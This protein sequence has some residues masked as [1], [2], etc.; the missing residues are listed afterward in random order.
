MTHSHIGCCFHCFNFAISQSIC[1]RGNHELFQMGRKLDQHQ[2][3]TVHPFSFS[4]N[5][6]ELAIA[7]RTT[8]VGKNKPKN[9]VTPHFILS[10]M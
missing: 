7:A 9:Q 6:G 3:M 8:P 1:F 4:V 2:V 5:N 10:F